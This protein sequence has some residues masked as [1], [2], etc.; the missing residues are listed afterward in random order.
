MKFYAAYNCYGTSFSYDSYGWSVHV[1]GNKKERDN[2][3][4]ADTF[5]NGNPTREMITLKTALKISD[6][7][8][9][10]RMYD[11]VPAW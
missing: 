9:W 5:P 7:N 1:F 11:S 8:Q 6:R 10:T 3:V 4:S 2:W